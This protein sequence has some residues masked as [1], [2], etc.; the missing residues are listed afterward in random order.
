MGDEAV[1]LYMKC[2]FLEVCIH[3]QSLIHEWYVTHR[4]IATIE[5]RYN[6]FEFI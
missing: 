4:H 6:I 3:C 5:I 1:E 2:Y